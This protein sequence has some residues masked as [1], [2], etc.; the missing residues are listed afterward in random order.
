MPSQRNGILVYTYDSTLSHG[1]NFLKPIVPS[2]RVP[3][4]SIN[5]PVQPYENPILYKGQ[6]ITIDGVKVEVVESLNYD[7]IKIDRE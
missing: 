4:N 5:C 1:E 7:K 2:G 3:E 6:T